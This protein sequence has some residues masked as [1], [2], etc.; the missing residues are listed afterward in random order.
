MNQTFSLLVQQYLPFPKKKPPTG[1]CHSFGLVDE[2]DERNQVGW[3]NYAGWGQP[4]LAG[5]PS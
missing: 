2:R 4:L 1:G 3:A 5:V